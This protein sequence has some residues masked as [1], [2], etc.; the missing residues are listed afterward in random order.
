MNILEGAT[1][2]LGTTPLPEDWDVAVLADA[3]NRAQKMGFVQAQPPRVLATLYPD[4]VGEEGVSNK[5]LELLTAEVAPSYILDGPDGLVSYH[6]LAQ[7]LQNRRW[8]GLNEAIARHHGG[9]PAALEE[10]LPLPGF[11]GNA[12]LYHSERPLNCQALE[13]AYSVQ[14]VRNKRTLPQPHEKRT[15]ADPNEL[16]EAIVKADLPA[17]VAHYYP[18]SGA[19][20]GVQNA[21]K[22]V[23]RGDENPSFS[24]FRSERDDAWL[25]RDH[26][27]GETGNAFGF[28]VDILKLPKAEA[29]GALKGR[30]FSLRVPNL[31]KQGTKKPKKTT[32]QTSA[33][34][35]T[36]VRSRII[37]TYPYT[38]ES[39][40]LLFEV[41]RFEPKRFAQRRK[42]PDTDAWI[43][44]LKAGGYIRNNSGDWVIPKHGEPAEREFPGCRH[45]L[46]HLPRLIATA[47]SKETVYLVEGEKDVETL[48][49]F[50]LTAT[51]NPMGSLKWEDGYTETLRGRQVVNLRD[52]DAAGE[53]HAL[54]VADALHRTT[55]SFINVLLPGLPP[56]GDVTDWF[57]AGGTLERFLELTSPQQ[58][59]SGVSY[60]EMQSALWQAV[61][62]GMV[63]PFVHP[64]SNMELS[65]SNAHFCL[66]DALETPQ[67]KDSKRV[68]SEVYGVLYSAPTLQQE[69][70]HA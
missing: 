33:P 34:K 51:C 20:P 9:T 23:W 14:E 58:Q 53:K 10:I 1:L 55:E 48:E 38:D 4:L 70:T 27:T 66:K 43:W 18:E 32:E 30:K 39:Y 50:D 69:G 8:T 59:E 7:P 56:G 52:N 57:D 13:Q 49:S 61:N 47:Q 37:K 11:R 2:Y 41:V 29:A 62:A 67:K 45:V 6:V 44:G 40:N 54:M 15:A 46:Y 68:I 26:A 19:Q 28:L 22:A 5:L 16:H 24:L 42:D 35:K 3:S 31:L 17:L 65:S 36:F 63:Q 21:V 12:L 64:L 60:E 25:Y